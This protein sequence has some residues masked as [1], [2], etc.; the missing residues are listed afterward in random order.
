MKTEIGVWI[1]LTGIYLVLAGQVSGTEAAMA[2]VGGGLGAAWTRAVRRASPRSYR[3]EIA[4]GKALWLAVAHLPRATIGVAAAFAGAS[5][6]AGPGRGPSRR[7]VRGRRADPRAAGRRALAVLAA[8][9]APDSFVLRVPERRDA[10][11]LHALTDGAPE[12]DER[13]P[14]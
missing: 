8:S 7:F 6:S 2:V 10:M 13:W 12:G 9:L 14:I 11:R 1:V 3:F 4:D 5:P